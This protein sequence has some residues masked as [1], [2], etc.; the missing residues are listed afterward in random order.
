MRKTFKYKLHANRNTFNKA[1][2][3]LNLCRFLYNCALAQRI[4]AYRSHKKSISYNEQQNELTGIRQE[5]IEYKDM[6]V[7]VE[8][9]VLRKLDH[10]YTSFYQ[11]L[12]KGQKGGYPRFKSKDRY[13]SFTLHEQYWKL[14]GKYL[15]ISKLGKFKLSLSR[16]ILGIIKSITIKHSPT[17]K[18]YVCFSCDEVPEKKLPKLIK[19][20]GVDVGVKSYL[21]DSE[22]NKVENPKFLKY[23]LRVLRVKQRKLSRAQRCSNNRKEDRLQVAKCHD[24][25]AN[26]RDDFL[27]KLSNQYVSAYGI[28]KVENLQIKNMSQNHKLAR[29]INDCAW[30]K[31]FELL[32]YKAEEAGRKVIKVPAK[33][34]SK[35]CNVCGAINHDLKLSDRI[36]ICENCGTTHDRDENA[37]INI[38]DSEVRAEPSGVNV[39]QKFVRS[40]KIIE[41]YGVS[42]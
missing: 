15:I 29:D 28:I 20:I 18:W 23:Q 35:R 26:Q 40:P 22:G 32:S 2:K 24:H 7:L 16:P 25:V 38:R 31:F 19:K 3:W 17:N 30:G 9:D 1:E 34:T 4:Y 41:T 37:S 13:N 33:N 39:K 11:R 10:A 14:D 27:H 21:T 36:W 5:Y 6:S 8:R 12:K 42:V